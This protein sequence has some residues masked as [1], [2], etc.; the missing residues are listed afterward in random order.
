ML[1]SNGTVGCDGCKVR[2]AEGGGTHLLLVWGHA[3]PAGRSPAVWLTPVSLTNQKK[4]LSGLG[5]SLMGTMHS[6]RGGPIRLRR[7][8]NLVLSAVQ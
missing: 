8:T 1:V 6:M 4:D 7:A 3:A 2:Y 5:S